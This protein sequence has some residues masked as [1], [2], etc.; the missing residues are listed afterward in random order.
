MLVALFA[1]ALR[2]DLEP[3]PSCSAGRAR[4]VSRGAA[5]LHR[6]GPARVLGPRR[7]ELKLAAR[8]HGD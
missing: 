5:P 4:C 8:T 1:G 7:E 2:D 6:R 3:Q